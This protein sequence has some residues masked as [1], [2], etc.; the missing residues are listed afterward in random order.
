MSGNYDPTSWNGWGARGD[1]LYF[2][3]PFAYLEHMHGDHLDWLR[4]TVFVQLCVGSRVVGG[5]PDQARC[6][7]PWP[8]VR[9]LQGKGIPHDLDVWGEDTPH[10]WPSW[11]LMAAKHLS[12][13]G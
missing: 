4:R 7:R 9:L 13:L 2:N 3:S 8:W 11:C 1:A 10:D 5:A 6:P 12:A